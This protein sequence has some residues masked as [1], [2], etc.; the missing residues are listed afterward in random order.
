MEPMRAPPDATDAMTPQGPPA[1]RLLSRRIIGKDAMTGVTRIAY[2][3][4]VEFTNRHG[5][6][7][8]GFLAV[9][10]DSAAALALISELADGVTAVTTRLEVDFLHAALPGE[11]IA[12][13]AVASMDERRARVGADLRNSDDVVV[14]RANV[15]LRI[16]AVRRP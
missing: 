1:S 16:I 12:N 7:Q 14:A 9:M 3:A 13:A 5:T 2:R 6:V 8:G 4:P 11:L 15:E 10:L